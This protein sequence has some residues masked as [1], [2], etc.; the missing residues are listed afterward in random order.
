[1][2]IATATKAALAQISISPPAIVTLEVNVAT[3]RISS[4]VKTS[5]AQI[6]SEKFLSKPTILTRLFKQ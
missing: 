3:L 1:M 5:N 2:T 6:V 4:T